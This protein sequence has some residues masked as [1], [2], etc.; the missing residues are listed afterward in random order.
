VGNERVSTQESRNGAT[1]KGCKAAVTT[2]HP[3]SSRLRRAEQRRGYTGAQA[4][5]SFC[6]RRGDRRYSDIAG[7][8]APASLREAAAGRAPA[9]TRLRPALAGLRRGKQPL[10]MH[11]NRLMI[12][13]RPL[14]SSGAENTLKPIL[15]AS[16][17][18]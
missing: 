10:L 4:D 3:P 12:H 13:D 7:D 16:D 2:A 17:L 14:Q 6:G 5:Y 1:V 18:S 9:A 11:R 8:T 15:G